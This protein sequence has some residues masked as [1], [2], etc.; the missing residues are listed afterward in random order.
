MKK[1]TALFLLAVLCGAPPTSAAVNEKWVERTLKSLTL[2]E[3]IGQML[4]P[5]N[6]LGAF[7]NM[8]SDE[9]QKIRSD[10]VDY[11]AGGYHVFGGDPAAVALIINEIQRLAKVPLLVADNFEG[12]VGYVL[13]G[14]TRFPLGMAMGATGDTNVAYEAAKRTA[15][16]GRAIGVNVNFYPVADVQNNPQNPIINIRSFGEDP[17]TVSR[18]VRAYIR[19]AEDNGQL[20]TAKHFPGHGDVTGD[21][22]LMMPVLDVA[23]QRLD[24]IELPPFRAAIEENVAAVMSAHIWLPQLES[25]K[26]LP[27]TLSRNVMTEL[28]RKELQYQGVIFT[29]A[30][31]MR[32]VTIAFPHEEASVRAIEAGNDMLIL[33]PNV[34]AAFNGLKAAV[35][36]GRL[37]EA[38]IDESV[39]RILRAKA[40]LGLDNPK[41]RFTDVNKL[42][43]TVATKANRDFAQQIEDRAIT[44]VR[45]ER[46]VLPLRASPDLRVVQINVVDTR[47]GWREGTVGGKGA[48]ELVKRFPRAVTVRVDDQS[49]PA[50][51]D[52]VRKIAQIADALIVNGYIRVAA[53]KG[54]IDLTTSQLSLIRDLAASKKPF[55]FTIFGSPYVLTHIPDIP[56]YIVTYDTSPLAESAAVRAITGEIPFTGKLP[57]S[58]PGFYPVGHG[59]T[60]AGR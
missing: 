47:S 44:L 16:E 8:E 49:T 41:A 20:A 30:M 6:A 27:S 17:A 34:A 15:Q 5:G 57:I 1:R 50:E 56:S 4:M 13:F 22:H 33:P 19:G 12:G 25:E 2:D 55:V 7:R 11:H 43:T 3:K 10:V 51:F 39:R 53:Y 9:F 36:S 45:D 18:F 31:G 28:L 54:S 42:M 29:D 26:G 48:E 24:T 52:Q 58:L 60:A 40:R 46:G 32:G 23:R 37:T 59:M 21:S 38:R 35:A 14:A